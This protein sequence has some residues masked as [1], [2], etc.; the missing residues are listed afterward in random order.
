MGTNASVGNVGKGVIADM[1]AME[2]P[3]EGHHL[4]AENDDELFK[5]TR[6]HADEVHLD[7]GSPTSSFARSLRR[8]FT[9]SSEP[10]LGAGAQH[11]RPF[12]LPSIH[13]SVWKGCSA[14]FRLTEF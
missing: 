3:L 4:E 14:N 7:Q 8:T 10:A 6:K 5:A 2:C 9:S 1:R 11:P 12:P 13:L